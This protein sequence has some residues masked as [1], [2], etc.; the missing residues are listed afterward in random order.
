MTLAHAPTRSN[1]PKETARPRLGL[2]LVV[3]LLLFPGGCNSTKSF[4]GP[5][6]IALEPIPRS[7][8][9][10]QRATNHWHAIEALRAD[11]ELSMSARVLDHRRA[12]VEELERAISLDPEVVLYQTA[13]GRLLMA[14]PAESGRGQLTPLEIGEAERHFAM[15]NQLN[16]EWV[17]A[18][19][20]FAQCL[21]QRGLEDEALQTLEDA[22]ASLEYLHGEVL[23]PEEGQ[24]EFFGTL[25]KQ[26]ALEA[27]W[28]LDLGAGFDP[29][30]QEALFRRLECR[31][32]MEE[33][34]VLARG[35][36]DELPDQTACRR[37]FRS[38]PTAFAAS[39]ALASHAL[40]DGDPQEVVRLLG[41][42]TSPAFE[43][44]NSAAV[45]FLLSE[46][47]RSL[48][49]RAI[50][51]ATPGE[52]K[53]YSRAA[54][55][56]LKGFAEAHG[57]ALD[58]LIETPHRWPELD[59]GLCDAILVGL[60]YELALPA[61]SSEL[62]ETLDYLDVANVYFERVREARVD[63]P[64]VAVLQERLLAVFKG[65]DALV[66][67]VAAEGKHEAGV[68]GK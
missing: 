45:R 14:T 33:A 13:L 24:R 56:D 3:A 42:F 38:D 63:H 51:S 17:P 66:P 8:S 30:S 57:L 54:V 35:R 43:L 11:G 67:E 55:A 27:T 19:I 18:R 15:A 40:R 7:L 1:A 4:E 34:W 68:G 65:L 23:S 31:I 44:A 12:A 48:A 61:P 37:A 10:F 29:G 49:R 47:R 16:P 41:D 5:P 9:A 20:G 53:S 59:A 64:K 2:Y 39:Y 58:R 50:A 26:L 22:Q 32:A 60:E 21:S 28:E 6:P 25:E 36:G 52:A 62:Q 46:A